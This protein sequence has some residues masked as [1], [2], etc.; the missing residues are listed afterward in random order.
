MPT[1]PR[2]LHPGAW[3]LWALGVAV[4]LGTSTNPV[5][6]GPGLLVVGLV[7]AARRGDSPWARAFRLYLWLG[8]AIVVV[9]V[10]LHIAVGYKLG[11]HLLFR[12]PSPTL[13]SWAAGITLGGAVYVEGLLGAAL[14]GLRLAAVIACVGAANALANPKRMLRALPGALAEIGTAVVVAV[15]VAPQ[16]AESVQ[17]VLR[18]RTL[19][20]QSGTGLRAVPQVALPVLQDTLDR[21]LLLAASMDSRGYGRRASVSPT[22]HTVSAALSLGGLVGSAVGIYGVLDTTAPAL[23][24][25]PLL[26]LGVLAAVVGVWL[27]GR[28]VVRSSYRPDPWAAPEWLSATTGVV[29]AG[30]ALVA[31]RLDP[32]SMAQPLQPLAWPVVPYVAVAGLLVAA[33]PAFL[34]PQPP[35]PRGRA[36]VRGP[37]PVGAGAPLRGAGR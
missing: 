7:V 36:S 15:T 5:V 10:V 24:G 20:G 33:L 37:E 14:E 34:T 27:G 11:S 22:G 17:R 18:A 3:W 6:L 31:V 2:H 9:R 13:P 8:L 26:L 32:A 16:L 19:R 1:L 21:S 30:A 12:L 23:L 4:A 29:A 28:S 25:L 35:R